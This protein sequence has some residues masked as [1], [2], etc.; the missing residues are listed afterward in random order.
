MTQIQSGRR[1]DIDALRVLA[2]GILILY[3]IGMYYVLDWGFHVKSPHQYGWLQDV[4]LLP[5]QW[6]MSLLFMISGMALALVNQKYSP[7]A[8]M[9]LRTKRL[10]IPLIFSMYVIVAPQ[11]YFQLVTRHGYDA[12]YWSF[13]LQYINIHTSLYPQYQ[14]G[15]G[16]L[17]WNHL[18]Y[19]PYLWCYSLVL[20]VCGA[21]LRRFA[22]W[23]ALQ[24]VKLW[25]LILVLMVV[26]T[27]LWLTLGLRF[28]STHA[29]LDDW[30]NHGKF[31]LAF[32]L[33]YVLVF[34]Q[35]WWQQAIEQRGKLLILAILAYGF[36]FCDKHD[37]L[38][39][40]ID[41]SG[42]P[43]WRH[44]SYAMGYFANHW[45][46]LLA[47]LGYGGY[48][49]NRS[50]RWLSYA[51]EAILPWYIFHQTLIILAAMALKPLQL[52]P[53]LEAL[54]ILLATCSGCALGYEV[55]KRFALT[56]LLFGLKVKAKASN[57]TDV[58]TESML[59]DI[60]A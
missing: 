4:M 32:M 15:L 56:R 40:W 55:V 16:L 43:M 19:L 51:N 39:D 48:Y 49:L 3:H 60:K 44:G 54:G 37:L 41:L 36:T 29:L 25:Q 26:Q 8:L 46:W 34:Q 12:S 59:N 2:F 27:A 35:S 22:N 38:P 7:S 6:R 10:M 5:N 45:L 30:Y 50:S 13:W 28:P 21:G 53:L 42:F 9:L 11:M 33:G 17:T 20:L 52:P 24:R 31:L 47:V 18:W 58:P 14:H 23:S 1:Y 57:A